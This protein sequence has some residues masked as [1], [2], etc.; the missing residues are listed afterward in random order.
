MEKEFQTL[1]GKAINQ[2]RLR[3]ETKI[4]TIKY[5]VG[6]VVICINFFGFLLLLMRMII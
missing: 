6:I 5:D 3:R 2:I 1:L 4:I